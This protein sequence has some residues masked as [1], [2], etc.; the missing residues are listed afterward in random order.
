MKNSGNIKMLIVSSLPL[1]F[2]TATQVPLSAASAPALINP[3]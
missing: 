3:N 1:K 2:L